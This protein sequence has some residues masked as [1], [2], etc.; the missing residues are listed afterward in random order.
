MLFAG[1]VDFRLKNFGA[2]KSLNASINF[3]E[4]TTQD[5]INLNKLGKVSQVGIIICSV[6]MLEDF[7]EL[8]NEI[9][10]GRETGEAIQEED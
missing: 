4:P 8:L 10:E 9:N 6:E 1:E 3:G 7:R 2:D 5:L